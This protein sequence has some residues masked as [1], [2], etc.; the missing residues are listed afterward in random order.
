MGPGGTWLQDQEGCCCTE[1]GGVRRDQEGHHCGTRRDQE[2]CYC[3]GPG[4]TRGD[5][6]GSSSAGQEDQ[7]CIIAQE[8]HCCVGP[9]GTLLENQEG[10]HRRARR[11]QEG[12]GCRTRMLYG[13]GG[14]RRDRH[15][16]AGRTRGHHCSGSR[17][18]SLENQEGCHRGARRDQ[19]NLE[20]PLGTRLQDQ[21]GCCRMGPG[22]TSSE[23]QK[24][25][26]GPLP[27]NWVR[28]GETVTRREHPRTPQPWGSGSAGDGNGRGRVAGR[29]V[30]A[31]T[32]L[33]DA[34]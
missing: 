9:G 2:G 29:D 23:H 27:E 13:T 21:E 6:E 32:L 10:H 1:P 4:G 25:P 17:G 26:G 16:G 28:P 31:R 3:M 12:R 5:K 20:G 8:R 22:E 19:E 18:T 15:Q 34:D 14:T 33:H 30:L 11:D 24:T 7:G